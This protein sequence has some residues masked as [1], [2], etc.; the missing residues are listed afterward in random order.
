MVQKAALPA[1]KGTCKT[2]SPSRIL[3]LVLIL[4]LAFLLVDWEY[5]EDDGF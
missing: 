1:L 3:L 2:S 5:I 4:I